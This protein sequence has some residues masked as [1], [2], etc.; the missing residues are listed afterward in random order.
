MVINSTRACAKELYK[1][2]SFAR[3]PY[4]AP[5]WSISISLQNR[6][7]GIVTMKL[8]PESFVKLL[9]ISV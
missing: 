7:I 9:R 6:I 5:F 4:F 2:F 1:L 8:N 3:F